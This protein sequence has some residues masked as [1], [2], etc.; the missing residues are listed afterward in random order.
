MID[1]EKQ[2]ESDKFYQDLDENVLLS[3]IIKISINQIP[4]K[5]ETMYEM[6]EFDWIEC[7]TFG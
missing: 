5:F 4:R 1:I 3:T 2:D 6:F 7:R